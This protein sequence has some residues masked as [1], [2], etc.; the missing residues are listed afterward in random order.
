MRKVIGIAII[1]ILLLTFEVNAKT[2]SSCIPNHTTKIY[3]VNG[4]WNSKA[5]AY[6]GL[7]LI[8]DAYKQTLE[9]QYPSQK[10]VFELAYNY[11]AGIVLDV[12][13]VIGQKLNEIDDP[14]IKKFTAEQ[15][16]HLFMTAYFVNKVS[17]SSI[18]PLLLTTESYLASRMLEVMNF[19]EHLE[20]YQTDLEEGKKILLIAHSQG[21]LFANQAIS[22]LMNSYSN[23][24]GMIGIAS[25]AARTY[26][27][28][29][30]YTAHDDRVINAL[31]RLHNV[32]PSNIDNDQ[33]VF[34][35]SRDIF[36]HQFKE[37]YFD[38]A[39]A[40]RTKINQDVNI[41][42]KKFQC[43][44]DSQDKSLKITSV[45]A[46]SSMTVP[47]IPPPHI[48]VAIGY[49]NMK[50]G[51]L[52]WEGNISS[53][54]YVAAYSTQCSPKLIEM[55]YPSIPYDT[56]GNF[57]WVNI[58]V[59]SRDKQANPIKFAYGCYFPNKNPIYTNYDITV[60]FQL[61]TGYKENESNIYTWKYNCSLEE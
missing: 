32:L 15:Y 35:D 25:P 40:S 21:N 43:S 2:N 1:I 55:I 57:N 23:N 11:H 5:E 20:G 31:R 22:S 44:E 52:Y 37:S 30:Y 60:Y 6:V 59:G 18:K 36:N 39:I 48:V 49:G 26:N 51:E 8:K 9:N 61:N 46:D 45:H 3:F 28:S 27:N 13:E 47:L 4:V 29:P 38:S 24:I 10:F 19:S 14:D 17:P 34:N 42:M 7:L 12:I 58:G 16:F 50:N 54:D 33:G 41:F 56:C 53:E